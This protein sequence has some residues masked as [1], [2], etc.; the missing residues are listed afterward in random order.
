MGANIVFVSLSISAVCPDG[1]QL[2]GDKVQEWIA[3]NGARVFSGQPVNRARCSV[4]S[5]ALKLNLTCDPPVAQQGDPTPDCAQTESCQGQFIRL[6][7][8][9]QRCVSVLE[10]RIAEIERRKEQ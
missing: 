2:D 9:M 1:C 6:A 3:L 10:L 4:C 7:D 8:E 5:K